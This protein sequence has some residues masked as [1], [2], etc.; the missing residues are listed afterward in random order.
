MAMPMAMVWEGEEKRGDKEYDL[1][2]GCR[3]S[4]T[5]KG[6]ASRLFHLGRSRDIRPVTPH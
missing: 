4:M 5:Q 3:E 1:S 2:F 6:G